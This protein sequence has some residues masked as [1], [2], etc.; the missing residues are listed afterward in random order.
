[1]A[2]SYRRDGHVL[3]RGLADEAEI[4]AFRPVIRDAAMR[5]NRENRPLE[6]RDVYGRAFLQVMNLWT[7]DEGVRRFVL[8][9]RFARVAA[10]LM[11]VAR[12]RLYHDQALFKEP[13][14][15]PT[16]FHQD[17]HYWPL[18]TDKTVTMWM[19]LVPVTE[20]VGGMTFVSGSHHLGGLG[21]L[22]ISDRSE[23]VF[24]AFIAE[25]GLKMTTHGAMNPGDATFHSGWTIHGAPPNPTDLVREIMTVIYMDAEAR[26]IPPDNP[27][28]ADDLATWLPGCQPGD[29]AASPLNPVVWPDGDSSNQ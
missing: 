26:V 9:R 24:R 1:M 3:I 14:G 18:D 15:G 8:A 17:Q 29:R 4:A 12:V 28:R 23:E 25:K 11:G 2:E 22:P 21:D 7:V 10:E 19:P 20:A 5:H 13:G 16:P 6:E 27:N